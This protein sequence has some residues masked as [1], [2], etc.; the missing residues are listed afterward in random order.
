M[1]QGGG[2]RAR[3]GGHLASHEVE[4]EG[5]GIGTVE[6]QRMQL[7]WQ[8]IGAATPWRG[9]TLGEGEC[10]CRLCGGYQPHG[11]LVKYPPDLQGW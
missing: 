3:G 9:Q 2:R 4:A 7:N 8:Y 10:G 11:F 6:G 1:A 5:G